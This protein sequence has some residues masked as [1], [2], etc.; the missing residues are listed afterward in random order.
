MIQTKNDE[1]FLELYQHTKTVLI[2]SQKHLDKQTKYEQTDVFIGRQVLPY[3]E[4]HQNTTKAVPKLDLTYS[5]KNSNLSIHTQISS[6]LPT[7]TW[8]HT[9]TA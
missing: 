9:S 8:L 7:C 6:L 1:M 5:G 2:H 3:S 4:R